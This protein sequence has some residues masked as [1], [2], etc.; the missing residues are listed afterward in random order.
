MYRIV[1]ISS[2]LSH[3]HVME[4]NVVIGWLPAA[5]CPGKHSI[6]GGEH[7]TITADVSS[8]ETNNIADNIGQRH[9]NI[10]E[11]NL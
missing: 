6:G 9:E 7:R 3:D 8:C 4:T 5:V 10:E 2:D 1:K 11:Q